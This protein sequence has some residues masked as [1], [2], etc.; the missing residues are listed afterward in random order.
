MLVTP[1]SLRLEPGQK[2]TL[3]PVSW[4]GFE[5]ILAEMGRRSS[6]IAYA[7]GVL[8]ITAPLPE[9]ELATEGETK[10]HLCRLPSS[11]H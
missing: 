9:H 1:I 3:Q 2:V 8:E 7:N 11:I 10:S 6:R 5:E 4:Q